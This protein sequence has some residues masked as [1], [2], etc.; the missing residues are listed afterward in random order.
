[1]ILS[2]ALKEIQLLR[3]DLHGVAVLFLLPTAFVIIMSLAIPSADEVEQ[4]QLSVF[5][6]SPQQSFTQ[7]LFGAFLANDEQLLLIDDRDGANFIIKILDDF[8]AENLDRLRLSM[9][10]NRGQIEQILIQQSLQS[11]LAKVKLREVL[12]DMEFIDEEDSLEAQVNAIESETELLPISITGRNSQTLP[13]AVQQSVPSWMIFGMFFIV[14]P[15]AQ[16]FLRE[17]Q[18]STVM[19]LRSFG[20]RPMDFIIS[21][22]FPYFVINQVQ[23]HL[24]IAVGYFVVPMLGGEAFRIHGAWINYIVLGIIISLVALALATL[25][26]VI[27]KTQEQAIVIGGGTNLI[28]AAIGGIMV[29]KYLMSDSIQTMTRFS[30]MGWSLDAFQ[31]LLLEAKGLGDI[32]SVML[33]MVLFSSIMLGLALA[34]FSRQFRTLGWN[35]AN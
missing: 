31:A 14:L 10:S 27:V 6:D 30:P 17:K 18:N 23:F 24:L 9:T 7:Q 28:L 32:G 1:M 13:S 21:K 8:D 20:L 12:L 35:S 15:F 16:T 4:R 22:I 2:L 33:V 5:L 29:P 3:H 25:I 34:A 11:A 26:A 19:R